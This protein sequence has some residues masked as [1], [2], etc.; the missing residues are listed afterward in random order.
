M[1]AARGLRHRRGA[2]PSR[3]GA[4]G[5]DP[6]NIEEDTEHHFQGVDTADLT[7][8][9]RVS[10]LAEGRR[11]ANGETTK[12]SDELVYKT[13]A[14]NRELSSE[15]QPAAAAVDNAWA[16]WVD[17]RIDQ[18]LEHVWESVGQALGEE[19]SKARKQ[20]RDKL[21]TEVNRLWAVVSELQ[22]CLRAYDRIIA[23]KE[24]LEMPNPPQRR[25]N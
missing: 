16:A 7:E 12:A 14:P 18:A 2:G 19:L 10:I 4:G 8:T 23:N 17:A 11:N 20:D 3:F 13:C 5:R 9:A 21:A 15:P 25:V 24:V 6:L 22:A 1:L